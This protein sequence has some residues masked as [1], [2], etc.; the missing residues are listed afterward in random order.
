MKELLVL[1]GVLLFLA[2]CQPNKDQGQIEQNIKTVLDAQVEAWN[3][4][5]ITTFMDYYWKSDE[6]SFQSGNGRRLGW[7]ALLKRYQTNYPVDKMGTLTFKDLSFKIMSKKIA[8]VLG[9]FFLLY[10]DNT[11]KEGLFTIIFKRLPEGW[12]IIHD[13]TSS[14]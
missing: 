8:Y 5:D 10:P 14:E 3:R 13:H 12:R 9:R 6:L 7:E 4:A 11:T 2:G 1:V